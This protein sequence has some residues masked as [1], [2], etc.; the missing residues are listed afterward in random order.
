MRLPIRIDF[1]GFLCVR[2]PA[3]LNSD[4]QCQGGVWVYW[5]AL[6]VFL[7]GFA[8]TKQ[9]FAGV[10]LPVEI[11]SWNGSPLLRQVSVAV[12][13][14][15]NSAT[16]LYCQ[17]HN[18]RFGG[19]VSVRVNGTS[20]T[21]CYNSSVEV[22]QPEK[23]QYGI[24][25]NNSTIRFT[26][27]LA[28]GTV[29]AGQNNSIS[30]RLNGTDSIVSGIRIIDFDFLDAGGA[31]L[32]APGELTQENPGSWT[33]PS[34]DPADISAGALLWAGASLFEDPIRRTPIRAKCASCHFDDG[35]DLTYF[36]FSNESIIT[37]SRFHGLSEAEGE[38][39]ASFIRTRNT[40]R[41][42]RPW[43]PPF[44]PGPG[45]DP[46]PGDSTATRQTKVESWMA[47][48]GLAWVIE[49]D[50]QALSHVFPGGTSHAS[51]SKIIDHNANFSVREVPIPFQ[52]ADWNAWLPEIAPEDMWTTANY[53]DKP[54]QF[55]VDLKNT[56]NSQGVVNLAA[57]GKL[58]KSLGDFYR[59]LNSWYDNFRLDGKNPANESAVSLA[60]KA[61]LTREDVIRSL[62]H[63]MAVKLIGTVREYDLEGLNDDTAVMRANGDPRF[64]PELLA[65]PGNSILSTVF[66]LAPH[67]IANNQVNF[68]K[69]PERIGKMESD[70]WYHLELCLNPGFRTTVGMNVPLDWDYQLLHLESAGVRGGRP[71]GIQHL[72]TQ[73]KMYQSRDN[74]D[75]IMKSGFSQRTLAPWRLFSNSFRDTS[76][77]QGALNAIEPGLWIKVFEEFM[78]EWLDVM[79]S[80]DLND[81]VL[82]PRTMERHELEPA[83]YTPVAWSGSGKYFQHPS[84][85]Y[86]DLMYRLFPL[87]PGAGVDEMLLLDLQ[88]WCKL[89]W[90]LGNWNSLYQPSAIYHENFED[91]VSDFDLPN[92]ALSAAA[93]KDANF[94]NTYAQGLRNGGGAYVGK[95]GLTSNA[96]RQGIHDSINVP[97][98]GATRLQLR[99]RV[100]FK[101]SDNTDPGALTFKMRLKFDGSGN[102][103]DAE[104]VLTLDPDFF[105]KEFESYESFLNV[106]SGAGSITWVAV[107]WERVGGSGGGTAYIDNIQIVA[108]DETVDST[109]PAPPVQ[110]N[111]STPS[112]RHLQANWNAS[113]SSDVLGYNVYRWSAG[114]SESEKIK[115]NT[116]LVDNPYIEFGDYTVDR[117]LRYNYHITAVDKAGNESAPSNTKNNTLADASTPLPTAALAAS[118][119]IGIVELKW[120]G[121]TAWDLGGYRVYRSPRGAASFSALSA[122][123]EPE[124][125]FIDS[126]AVVGAAYDYYV[127]TTDLSGNVSATSMIVTITN[128][129]SAPIEAWKYSINGVNGWDAAIPLIAGDDVDY[130]GDGV[131]NLWEYVRGTS[132][133]VADFNGI[134]T[135]AQILKMGGTDHLEVSYLRADS[136]PA[137]VIIGMEFSTDLTSW[138]AM[139]VV[140]GS[141]PS[142][143]LL[144]TQG[145]P[146]G[147]MRRVYA[148]RT[149]TTG[150]MNFVRVSVQRHAP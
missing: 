129:I 99:A 11:T 50:S 85:V 84:E 141:T 59:D 2:S 103:Y 52:F 71:F 41:P 20:W 62:V 55:Y 149:T 120:L 36:N 10:S 61:G 96:L 144:V 134:D 126:S 44:Q 30:F 19:Q 74:G 24:G 104:D 18:L 32:L 106:P 148:R 35:S 66:S 53:Y 131:P 110:S 65:V 37:R 68:E 56:L 25:G 22:L 95:R 16:H 118:S 83:S 92:S 29:G 40:P 108:I 14:G 17:I 94:V 28:P 57:Q 89:A 139:E 63:W 142:G 147:G 125:G 76:M 127:V 4:N 9:A 60:R 13:A 88:N 140:E 102:V 115:L 101:D 51:I 31:R 136:L 123:S 128:T 54:Y 38:Q 121:Q 5:L 48:A 82:V 12:P 15:A 77:H 7:G 46:D 23:S 27:P 117:D 130:D 86:A 105:A 107:W 135:L 70:Q 98:N 34:S 90:P 93:I 145:M 6:A 42:G 132:P 114:Q 122:A 58:G 119:D 81:P 8:G 143:N 1:Q 39:I 109:P 87:L 64:E 91:G 124:L 97:L 137:G 67:I 72:I 26:I 75:G 33:P 49:N 113:S 80:M 21:T 3:I 43:N 133:A 116:G 100:G 47:G 150:A 112:S 73:I 111:V 78:Y 138:S 146:S 69:Q 79:E 45:L